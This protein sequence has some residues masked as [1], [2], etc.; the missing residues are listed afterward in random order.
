MVDAKAAAAIVTGVL[1]AAFG[2]LGTLAVLVGSL[3]GVMEWSTVAWA[4]PLA[5][6]LGAGLTT[7]GV[8]GLADDLAGQ[9][10][11]GGLSGLTEEF[12]TYRLKELVD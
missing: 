2:G 7:W 4:L 5:L 9:L 1:L 11:D 10:S 12:D 6:V 3:A 8:V